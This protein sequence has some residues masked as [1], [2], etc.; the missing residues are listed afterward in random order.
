MK[1]Y[2]LEDRVCVC[3]CGMRFRTLP[4]SPSIYASI[5]HMNDFKEVWESAGKMKVLIKIRRKYGREEDP[6]GDEGDLLDR[7]DLEDF[8][9]LR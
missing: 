4:N 7:A 8:H 2:I 1:P 3:G 6:T 5:R 9:G